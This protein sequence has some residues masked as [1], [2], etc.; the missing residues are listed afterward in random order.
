MPTL[1]YTIPRRDRTAFV[2]LRSTF[3]IIWSSIAPPRLFRYWHPS[4]SASRSHSFTSDAFV[5]NGVVQPVP[6]PYFTQQFQSWRLMALLQLG[7]TCL[8]YIGLFCIFAPNVISFLELD[9]GIRMTSYFLRKTAVINKPLSLASIFRR[10]KDLYVGV[11]SSSN[12]LFL[13]AIIPN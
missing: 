6:A 9:L 2:F 1:Q 13:Y 4:H 5:A 11:A 7:T 8:W 3:G 10:I 12:L